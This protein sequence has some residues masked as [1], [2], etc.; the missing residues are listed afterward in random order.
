MRRAFLTF[1]YLA[2]ICGAALWAYVAIVASMGGPARVTE[3]DRNG[4]FNEA[5]L[6]EYSPRLADNLRYNVGNWIQEPVRSAAIHC[7][8]LLVGLALINVA[9]FH[10]V[11]IRQKHGQQSDAANAA[12][13]GDG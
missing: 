5:K 4:V 9:G 13:L 2:L 6:Q 12:E 1:N 7:T 11:G 10:F 8:Q 3:L